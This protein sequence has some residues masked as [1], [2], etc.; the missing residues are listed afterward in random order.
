M[1]ETNTSRPA[2]GAANR[3]ELVYEVL[4][5]DLVE[6][7]RTT[8]RAQMRRPRLRL[9]LIGCAAMMVVFG[10]AQNDVV[11][12]VSWVII[13]CLVALLLPHAITRVLIPWQ[14]GMTVRRDERFRHPWRAIIAPEAFTIATSQGETRYL[15]SAFTSRLSSPDMTLLMLGTRVF[16]P[17]PGRVLSPDDLAAIDAHMAASRPAPAAASPA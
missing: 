14:A 9:F 5:A 3:T 12:F 8:F 16:V 6:A 11:G 17:I 1:L 2:P 15:W 10:F 4:K 13:V 7:G